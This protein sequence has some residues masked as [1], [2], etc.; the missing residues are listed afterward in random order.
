MK[1]SVMQAAIFRI[2]CFVLHQKYV[3]NAIQRLS[4][5]TMCVSPSVQTACIRI[6]QTRFVPF[7]MSHA[8][9]VLVLLQV[10]AQ[11]ALMENSCMTS[12]A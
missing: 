2:V 6:E 4:F 7:A 12:N 1:I 10:I 5:L 8:I 9:T 11:V 3:A